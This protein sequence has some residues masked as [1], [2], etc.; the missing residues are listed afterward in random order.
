MF[1]N[2]P[3]KFDNSK[4]PWD[5]MRP[6]IFA[7]IKN[8]LKSGELKL[9]GNESL[10][11]DEK[12]NGNSPIRWIAG[13]LDGAFGRH[14]SSGKPD[15][16][17]RKLSKAL[18]DLLKKGDSRLVA[19]FY[20]LIMS[21]NA[22]SFLETML[23][24][25]SK[26][27]ISKDPSLYAFAKWLIKN[28]PDREVVKTGIALLGTCAKEDDK[29]LFWEIGTHEEFTLYCAAAL[30]QCSDEPELALF[31]L[32]KCV[33]GWGR[34][35]IVERLANTKN[36]TI[37][38]W[39]LR[40]GYRNSIMYEYTAHICAGTGGLC[41]QLS[42]ESPDEELLLS[43]TEII[44]AL[45]NGSPGPGVKGYS[46]SPRSTLLLL[47]HL[48][49]REVSIRQLVAVGSVRDFAKGSNTRQ[50]KAWEQVRNDIVLLCDGILSRSNWSDRIIS[51]SADSTERETIWYAQKAA[52]ILNVD[53]WEI[54][55]EK[56]Q[57]GEDHWYYI[58]QTNNIDR[59]KRAVTLAEE[60]LPLNEIA[61]GVDESVGFGPEFKEHSKLDWVLQ[62][63]RLWPGVGLKLI[64]TGLK[65]PVV[66]NRN[67][68]LMA[69]KQWGPQ[70]WDQEIT[71]E[72]KSLKKIEPN[73]K[74]RDLV[75]EL[76]E[77]V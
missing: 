65:S 13:G 16:T 18:K 31:E 11:D 28:A 15:E 23:E 45:I 35:E 20:H 33:D 9:E 22:S 76:L 70:F 59:L 75:R 50:L 40:E 74:T 37:K 56:L 19:V 57:K 32:A 17:G 26:R 36:E 27:E 47:K 77:L 42:V 54:F 4:A 6:S 44:E 1:K 73:E 5:V 48:S 8:H 24:E 34:I 43:A 62:Q 67:M 41:E 72:L 55:F 3:I 12:V 38:S 66:R 2:E 25:V 14:G 61:S 52:G 69:L 46:D 53:V 39:L 51:T 71:T 64:T 68:S 21:S 63:L 29:E 49:K 7:H 60:N 58:V 10:P 30:Q